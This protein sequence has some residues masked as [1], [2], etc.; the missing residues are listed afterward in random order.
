LHQECGS[1]AVASIPAAPV[2]ATT[3][4]TVAS[5]TSA[6]PAS[7]ATTASEAAGT[8]FLRTGFVDSEGSAHVLLT[9]QRGDRR[10]GFFIRRHFDESKTL[11]SAGLAVRNDLRRR[12][13]AVLTEQL[14]QI[15]VTALVTQIAHVKLLTHRSYLLCMGKHRPFD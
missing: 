4:T 9:I 10:L 8:F 14:G 3:A 15:C 13:I 2:A 6:T 5:A 7:T 11:A 1:V 12:D